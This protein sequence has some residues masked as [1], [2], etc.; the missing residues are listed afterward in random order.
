MVVMRMRKMIAGVAMLITLA[1]SA[2][3]SDDPIGEHVTVNARL[4]GADARNATDARDALNATRYARDRGV[5]ERLASGEASQLLVSLREGAANRSTIAQISQV[6]EITSFLPDRALIV[7][8]DIEDVSALEQAPVVSSV[9]VLE[10]SFKRS[11]DIERLLATLNATFDSNDRN[12]TDSSDADD[13]DHESLRSYLTS[14]GFAWRTVRISPNDTSTI[15]QLDVSLPS[16]LGVRGNDESRLGN[17][18]ALA[19]VRHTLQCEP[20][21][22]SCEH[23]EISSPQSLLVEVP[24]QFASEAVAKLAELPVVHFIEPV[25]DAEVQSY[26]AANVVQSSNADWS[27]MWDAGLDG[28]G[29]L[30]ACGDTGVDVSH[31]LFDNNAYQSSWSAIG[32]SHRKIEAYRTLRGSSDSTGHGTHVAGIMLGSTPGWVDTYE[33]GV[34]KGA[35]L[36]FTD[37]SNSR[38][39]T[40]T[41]PYD[42]NEGYLK[43]SRREGAQINS[44]SWAYAS[45]E[46]TR[47]SQDVDWFLWENQDAISV[48]AAGNSGSNGPKSVKAP[49]TSKNAIAVGATLSTLSSSGYNE[50]KG[51]V[52]EISTSL[53]FLPNVGVL[54][55]YSSPG[56]R[57]RSVNLK[58]ADPLDGCSE[59]EQS[60]TD[61]VILAVKSDACDADTIARNTQNAGASGVVIINTASACGYE[62]IS[63]DAGGFGVF[64]GSISRRNGIQLKA[65]IDQGYSV[66][67][68]LRERENTGKRFE[69]AIADFSSRGPTYD[70]RSK[71]DIVAPGDTIKSAEAGSRCSMTYKGGTSMAAPVVAGAATIVRQ[72]LREGR[73][74]GSYG[75]SNPSGP[76]LKAMLIN[77]ADDMTD[78][79]SSG[80]PIE[81][82][83][84]FPA[85]DQGFGRVS[86]VNS[87]PID[88][89]KESVIVFDRELITD[90]SQ[91]VSRCFDVDTAGH[92]LRVTMAYHDHPADSAAELKLVN[93]LDLIVRGPDFEWPLSW[94]DR[95]NNVERMLLSSASSGRYEVVVRGYRVPVDQ[96]FAL[97]IAGAV[98]RC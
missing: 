95:Y 94:N 30:V 81:S 67:G 74:L 21:S 10:S 34:A 19:E 5:R 60:R 61:D 52:Y 80:E 93:D 68:T 82:A 22:T 13:D 57:E 71:P 8:G 97:A 88:K 73:A 64:V 15:I 54:L 14:S 28:S 20:K 50:Q 4:R 42:L 83:A 84:S 33:P 38:R 46:Y 37:L 35:R 32:P 44:E 1:G 51:R 49:A 9:K 6:T 25:V 41:P 72:F 59:M 56:S 69:A 77:S 39:G 78:G 26:A 55:A 40:I 70:L 92:E 7:L 91:E 87:L 45:N 90:E 79:F 58:L 2:G 43:K 23:A 63:S 3:A 75:P 65:H 31:C 66:S 86:L 47:A 48:F 85:C 98:S 96:P 36:I 16:A 53:G 89:E 18:F 11:P 62:T 76:L 29:E 12:H 17:V 24:A 27:I